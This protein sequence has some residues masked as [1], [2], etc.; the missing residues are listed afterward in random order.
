MKSNSVKNK[1]ERLQK[2]LVKA[3]ETE[4]RESLAAERIARRQEQKEREERRK[5]NIK[6]G[7]VVQVIKNTKKLMYN[8]NKKKIKNVETRDTN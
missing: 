6:K 8:K 7:E 2:Q 5:A 3:K 1:K 4:I